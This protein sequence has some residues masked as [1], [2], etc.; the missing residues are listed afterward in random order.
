MLFLKHQPGQ[1]ESVSVFQFS[2]E[3]RRITPKLCTVF[4]AKSI[5]L[6]R[7]GS[8][9]NFTKAFRE[10]GKLVDQCGTA[11]GIPIVIL[12]SDGNGT[13]ENNFVRPIIG[14][15]KNM[16]IYTIAF[17]PKASKDT[18]NRIAYESDSTTKIGSDTLQTPHRNSFQAGNGEALQNMFVEVAKRN[19]PQFAAITDTILEEITVEVV[20]QIVSD[21]L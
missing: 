15:H 2:S 21:Y 3:T 19:P 1:S 4:E 7:Q 12:M 5:V 11:H 14:S 17:G 20:N 6:D 13:Y 9:T 16:K 8:G 10:V 18:L